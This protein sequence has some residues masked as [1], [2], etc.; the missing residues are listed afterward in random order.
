L[1]KRAAEGK[2]WFLEGD[3]KIS[4]RKLGQRNV[5]GKANCGRRQKGKQRPK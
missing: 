4:E 3:K 5:E 2:A 1:A